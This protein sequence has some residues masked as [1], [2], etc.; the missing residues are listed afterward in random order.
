MVQLT[1]SVPPT[2]ELSMMKR[3]RAPQEPMTQWWERMYPIYLTVLN[4][5][6]EEKIED[7]TALETYNKL[8]DHL[9]QVYH[10]PYP[11]PAEE[12]QV[13]FA[14]IILDTIAS[15]SSHFIRD[16]YRTEKNKKRAMQG[17]IKLRKNLKRANL[18]IR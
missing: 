12:L 9:M 3:S 16:A 10:V 8:T 1:N 4:C 14:Q 17:M 7:N 15:Y 11:K 13:L 6:R 2:K 5:L 18:R